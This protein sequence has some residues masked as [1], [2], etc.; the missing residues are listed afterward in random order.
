MQTPSSAVAGRGAEKRSSRQLAGTA[1]ILTASISNQTGAAIGSLAFT[2]I[3][4]VGVVAVRQ[5]LTAAVLVPLVRVPYRAL[6]AAQWR[7]VLGLAVVFCVMNLSLYAAIER[8]GLGLAVTLEFL[9]PLAIGLAG[10]RRPIDA[11]F[12]LLA[13]GGVVVLVRPGPSTD[14]AGILL[15]LTAAACWAAYIL[16]NRTAG[17]RLPGLQA[18]TAASLCTTAVWVP[19]ALFWFLRHPPGTA[20]LGLAL[21]CGALASLIPYV[22]DLLALR[23]IP[24]S[25]FGVLTSI[26]PI[27][28]VLAGLLVLGQQLAWM[29]LAGIGLIVGGSLGASLSVLRTRAVL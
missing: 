5:L 2:A 10:S 20:A 22:I 21:A 3:G 7:P 27:W 29:D 12:A 1:M 24:A 16:L 19:V 11:L 28:A 23:R 6:S 15:A 25:L 4:P 26:N 14:L 18:V 8:I 17:Q 13:G 9:G